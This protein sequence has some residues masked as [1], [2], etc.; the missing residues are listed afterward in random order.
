[1]V[2]ERKTIFLFFIT[3]SFEKLNKSGNKKETMLVVVFV[4][5]NQVSP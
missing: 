2:I 1:L 5:E 4:G 3:F